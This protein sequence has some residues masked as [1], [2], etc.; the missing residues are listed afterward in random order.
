MTRS[1]SWTT[2]TAVKPFSWLDR[3]RVLSQR[4][5][6][7]LPQENSARSCVALSGSG[8][9]IAKRQLLAFEPLFCFDA[10]SLREPVSTL[11]EN[12][13]VSHGAGRWKSSIISG[14]AV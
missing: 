12:A 11:L 5:R 6:D 4:S 13:L 7:G 8:P 9:K 14:T 2:R 3:A 10:F 1:A